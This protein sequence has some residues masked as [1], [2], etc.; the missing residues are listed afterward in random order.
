MLVLL[1]IGTIAAICFFERAHRRIPVQYAKRQ[2]GRKMYQGAQSF[3]PL[4]INVSGVIPPIF[5][6]SI[7][8]FPTQIASMSGSPFLQDVASAL[9]PMPTGATTSSSRSW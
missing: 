9:H 1:V 8:M 5:A 6:S 2:V 4:K 3:L 7:L